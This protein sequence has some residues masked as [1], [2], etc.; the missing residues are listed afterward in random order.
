M[1]APRLIAAIAAALALQ[2]CAEAMVRADWQE[3]PAYPALAPYHIEIASSELPRICG[4]HP[5]TLHGCAIRVVDAR[6][7]L[8]YTGPRPA[9]WL[10]EHEHKHCA[11]WDHGPANVMPTRVAA[12]SGG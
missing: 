6:V 8:I 11:G 1:T 10:M 4:A 5:G 9:A 12:V 2:G 7:C 3:R